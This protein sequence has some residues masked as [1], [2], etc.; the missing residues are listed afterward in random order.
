MEK[1]ISHNRGKNYLHRIHKKYFFISRLL[2]STILPEIII[3]SDVFNKSEMLHVNFIILVYK[4]VFNYYMI[5]WAK[6]ALKLNLTCQIY[7]NTHF[8][9]P[10]AIIKSKIPFFTR[11]SRFLY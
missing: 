11:D 4:K 5:E 3:F 9:I 7:N 1:E 2:Q 6:F 8:L 10:D